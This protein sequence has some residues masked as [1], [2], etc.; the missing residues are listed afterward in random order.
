MI[1]ITEAPIDHA[2]LTE[3]VRSRQAGAVCTFLGTVREMTGDRQTLSLDYEAY[4]EMAMKKLAELEE[5]ARSRWPII[6][7]ALV[8]RVGHLELGEVSVVVAVSCPHRH[9]AFDACRWLIDTLK[10]V[11]PI[12]KQE[13]WADGT[14]EW[15]H[16]GLGDS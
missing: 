14:L 2:A 6:E 3:H 9:Q 8:H 15:V 1:E 11:V 5:Q 16:P 4:P 7:L 10:E 13:R 12:W